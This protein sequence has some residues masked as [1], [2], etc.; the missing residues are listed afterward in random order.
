MDDDVNNAL[1]AAI[2]KLSEQAKASSNDDKKAQGFAVAVER[3]SQ[4]RL[5]LNA[6]KPSGSPEN[7]KKTN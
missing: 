3:L 5:N 7:N 6:C 1:K 2:I 4:A